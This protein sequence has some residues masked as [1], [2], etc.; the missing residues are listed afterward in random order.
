[1]LAFYTSIVFYGS[2]LVNSCMFTRKVCYPVSSKVISTFWAYFTFF[3]S[4]FFFIFNYYNRI[5]LRF[6]C[7]HYMDI[8]SIESNA[9]STFRTFISLIS[10][11][12]PRTTDFTELHLLTNILKAWIIIFKQLPSELVPHHPRNFK[13]LANL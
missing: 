11:F 10:D 1:M 12:H 5:C 4:I 13:F 9:I 2:F 8:I 6:L 3:W 7:L